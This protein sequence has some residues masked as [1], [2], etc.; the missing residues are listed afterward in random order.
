MMG[1]GL[2]GDVI[3]YQII[4]RQMTHPWATDIRE[5]VI[6]WISKLGVLLFGDAPASARITGMLVFLVSVGLLY[7]LARIVTG[8]KLIGLVAM[9]LFG[10]NS[11]MQGL[12]V[13]GIRDVF[14]VLGLLLFSI[15]VFAPTERLT[16]AARISLLCL[17]MVF[18]A[19]VRFSAFPPLFLLV[20]YAI[21]RHKL[22]WW[23][24]SLL[25]IC[26]VLVIVA[27]YLWHCYEKFGD[28]LFSSNLHAKW[29]RNYEYAYFGTIQCEGCPDRDS[30]A[31][32]P[33]SG[34]PVTAFSYIFKY[35]S[36][37]F[38]LKAIGLGAYGLS[39]GRSDAFYQLFDTRSNVLFYLY[40]LG[41]V[42]VLLSHY[43]LLLLVPFLA[44]NFVFFSV[45]TTGMDN[46]L[47][48][49]LCPVMSLAIAVG[50]VALL[51]LPY[52][53]VRWSRREKSAEA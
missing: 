46:R 23:K 9:T 10:M 28:P 44:I 34:P 5:P 24:T 19:G 53:V 48:T 40:G 27:P 38:A 18:T 15:G 12:A 16:G 39:I 3:G 6:I 49:P 45:T 13:Q 50:A 37:S 52:S 51:R 43:R 42:L 30:M 11:Y 33:Y 20:P 2:W 26:V 47:Y 31:K 32:D 4:A 21:W 1:E 7:S 35:H 25:P 22:S 8:S 41:L 17:G 14:F 29:W 36:I